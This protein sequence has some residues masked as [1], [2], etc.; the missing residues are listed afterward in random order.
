MYAV[1]VIDAPLFTDDPY[2]MFLTAA[3]A[4]SWRTIFHGSFA[5]GFAADRR[6]TSAQPN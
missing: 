2:R 3:S 5:A 4:G 1:T 6:L